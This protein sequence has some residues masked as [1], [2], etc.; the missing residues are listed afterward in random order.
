M[1]NTEIE[2]STKFKISQKDYDTLTKFC[3]EHKRSFAFFASE[4]V[5]KYCEQIR[6]DLAKENEKEK[7]NE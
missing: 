2:K 7:V 4:A 1:E 5:E 6:I 3:K